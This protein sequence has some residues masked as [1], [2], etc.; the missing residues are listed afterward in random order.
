[1]A[2]ILADILDVCQHFSTL[3]HTPEHYCPD[4][5][6]HCYK[7]TLWKHGF[8][9]RQTQRENRGNPVPV[10]RFFCPVCKHTCSTLP[11]Y[12]PPRRWYYWVTQQAVLLLLMLGNSVAMVCDKFSYQRSVAPSIDTIYRW[13]RQ[14]KDQFLIHQFHLCDLYPE[15]RFEPSC[16]RFWQ[17][18]FE[19][20]GG[21]SS[22]MLALNRAN[23]RVP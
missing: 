22:A 8:Y 17:R 21:L 5:C 23:Q 19:S 10:P 15:L 4:N 9:Y 3:K 18:Y 11:E 16:E 20:E 13:W 7:N 14:L 6:P 12:I 2:N 1:M